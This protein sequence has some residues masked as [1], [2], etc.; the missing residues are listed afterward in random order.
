M[1]AIECDPWARATASRECQLMNFIAASVAFWPTF[2]CNQQSSGLWAWKL[3]DTKF[4]EAL[5]LRESVVTRNRRIHL[6][7]IAARR[8]SLA[9]AMTEGTSGPGNNYLGTAVYLKKT[10]ARGRGYEV[11]G[12]PEDTSTWSRGRAV[13]A[14]RWRDNPTLQIYFEHVPKLQLQ[15]CKYGDIDISVQA[16]S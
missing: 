16:G 15:V 11:L 1:V 3:R 5:V 10:N 9:A 12:Y 7:I 8:I 6:G 14:L 13:L 2:T 4:G